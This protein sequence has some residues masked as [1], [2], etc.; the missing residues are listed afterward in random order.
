MCFFSTDQFTSKLCWINSN[1]LERVLL[2]SED[3]GRRRGRS[4]EKGAS[5]KAL[6]APWGSKTPLLLS[7]KDPRFLQHVCRVSGSFQGHHST[8]P[9]LSHK[10][11]HRNTI[12]E[13]DTLGGIQPIS[14]FLPVIAFLNHRKFHDCACAATM[15]FILCSASV[16]DI[17]GDLRHDPESPGYRACLSMSRAFLV[18]EVTTIIFRGKPPPQSMSSIYSAPWF[19]MAIGFYRVV[20]LWI[21]NEQTHHASATLQ[22][23]LSQKKISRLH[24]VNP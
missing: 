3:A 11:I 15:A 14:S 20:L 7:G 23:G 19:S 16:P 13:K 6:R 22:L 24:M 5:M 12:L 21:A 2:W 9:A 4:Q 1:Q 8:C 10:E 18:P 17:A